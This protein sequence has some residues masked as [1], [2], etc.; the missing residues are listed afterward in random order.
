M[1]SL[2]KKQ[3][4]KENKFY[5]EI[6]L[7]SR[8]KALYTKLYLKDTFQNRIN[9]IFFHFSFMLTK[10]KLKKSDNNYN[11]FYQ[12]TFDLIFKN[13]EIN[14][15]ELGQGDVS[16]NKNMKFL[17]KI[18]Y[19]ILLNCETYSKKKLNDKNAFLCKYL[20]QN[21]NI[22]TPYNDGLVDYFDKYESFCFDLSVDNVLKC[23]FK[24]NYK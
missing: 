18:F 22:N 6:L 17:V 15:R 4:K 11:S 10:L 13:I 24:F 7:L 16:V 14:M 1:H 8:N 21:D 23:N 9:L 12:K 20:V 2:F 3:E 19:N 5:N